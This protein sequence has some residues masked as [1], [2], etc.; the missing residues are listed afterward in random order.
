MFNVSLWG[1]IYPLRPVMQS[2]H[3]ITVFVGTVK[4]TLSVLALVVFTGRI[5]W[6]HSV[7]DSV[8]FLQDPPQ[9]NYNC[10][11]PEAWVWPVRL[12]RTEN[13]RRRAATP[14]SDQ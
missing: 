1:E 14:W 4:E 6:I 8:S 9:I 7:K 3:I 11:A 5:R 12:S 10:V 2:A 13:T